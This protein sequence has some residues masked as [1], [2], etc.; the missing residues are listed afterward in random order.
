MKVLLGI[1]L[2]ILLLIHTLPASATSSSAHSRAKRSAVIKVAK[3]KAIRSAYVAFLIQNEKDSKNQLGSNFFAWLNSAYALE[4][5]N[6]FFGGWP[7]TVASGKCVKPQ[8]GFQSTSCPGQFECE[9]EIFPSD[10]V[11]GDGSV[12]GVCVPTLAKSHYAK[13]TDSCAKASEPF[14]DDYVKKMAATDKK[15]F[16]GVQK[17]IDAFCALPANQSYDACGSLKKRLEQLAGPATPDTPGGTKDD[18]DDEGGAPAGTG[19]AGGAGGDKKDDGTPKGTKEQTKDDKEEGDGDAK[20]D[21]NVKTDGKK[22]AA[23]AVVGAVDKMNKKGK[24]GPSEPCPIT[25]PDNKDAIVGKN[26]AYNRCDADSTSSDSGYLSLV[27]DPKVKSDLPIVQVHNDVTFKSV[28]EKLDADKL[29]F[30]MNGPMFQKD[31]K[32]VGLLIQDGKLIQPLAEDKEDHSKG[33][34]FGLDGKKKG[35]DNNGVIILHK[36]GTTKFY[37]RM[38]AMA[39]I[40]TSEPVENIALAFQNGPILVKNGVVNPALDPKSAKSLPRSAACVTQSGKLR[41]MVSDPTNADAKMNFHQLASAGLQKECYMSDGKVLKYDEKDAICVNTIY[42]D[43][44]TK[45]DGIADAQFDH[46]SVK[47]THEGYK[48][49]LFQF[50]LEP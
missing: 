18:E 9:P 13:L 32:P 34:F 23:P 6:C 20:P 31:R 35:F 45:K 17:S 37:T 47:P 22:K 19:T 25:P 3:L 48:R 30:I 7:S 5:P 10:K 39:A 46:A 4:G 12:A 43:G 1:L 38:E 36:D 2:L 29:S 14:V 15:G 11:A 28:N 27:I 21:A 49:S 40:G 41:F 50:N 26:F 33:N 24:Q 8:G 16:A 44:S 42:I